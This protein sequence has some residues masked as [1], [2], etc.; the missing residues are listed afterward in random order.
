[1]ALSPSPLTVPLNVAGMMAAAAA[2]ESSADGNGWRLSTA[3]DGEERN[4]EREEGEA[5]PNVAHDEEPL[6]WSRPALSVGAAGATAVS[7]APEAMPS[8]AARAAA[9]TARALT[10]AASGEE[11]EVELGPMRMGAEVEHAGER[12]GERADTGTGA[13]NEEAARRAAPTVKA[14]TR[15]GVRSKLRRSSIMESI[16]SS[17]PAAKGRRARAH[18][19]HAKRQR[20][21]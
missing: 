14:A 13:A 5:G 17:R 8:A 3:V 21:A 10:T 15:V 6:E 4:A 1:M 20:Q 7:V 2:V 11:A 18:T 19:Q 9:A 16:A 12:A